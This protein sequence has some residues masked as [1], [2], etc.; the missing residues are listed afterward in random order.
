M[1]TINQRHT[2]T[3][4]AAFA[5][6]LQVTVEELATT[7]LQALL[8]DLGSVLIHAVLGSEAENVVDGAASISR[9]TMLANVLDAPVSELAVSDDIDASKDLIDTRSLQMVSKV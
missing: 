9:S 5:D 4:L 2:R 3:I 1:L 8:D 6:A 7:N